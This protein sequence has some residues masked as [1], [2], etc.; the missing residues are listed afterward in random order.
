MTSTS[1]CGWLQGWYAVS[2]LRQNT[3]HPMATPTQF[4]NWL[5]GIIPIDHGLCIVAELLIVV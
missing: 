3:S 2:L 1:D 5:I 4:I